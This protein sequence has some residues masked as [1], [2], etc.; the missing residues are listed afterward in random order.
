MIPTKFVRII[1]EFTIGRSQERLFF[2]MSRER[3][4]YYAYQ[5]AF[6]TQHKFHKH[7]S[8]QLKPNQ[9]KTVV[10]SIF[11]TGTPTI[12]WRY[13]VWK[14]VTKAQL[15]TQVPSIFVTGKPSMN[16][17]ILTKIRA[18]PETIRSSIQKR[19]S[20]LSLV[21]QTRTRLWLLPSL[22]AHYMNWR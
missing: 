14:R 22:E 15:I 8:C 7:K 9:N 17:K 18:S 5:I 2:V 3:L 4:H 1:E 10:A 20:P 6:A 21:Y 12:N 19:T 13:N 11:V 16:T